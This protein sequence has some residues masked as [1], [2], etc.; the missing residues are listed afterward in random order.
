MICIIDYGM[1]NIHSVANA[2]EKIGVSYV[3]SNKKEDLEKA[4]GLI[5]PGVGAFPDCM[6]NLDK[7]NLITLIK[8]EVAK[9]KPLLGI[10]LGMQ[11][12]FES[13]DEIKETK[14][15]GLLSGKVTYMHGCSDKV[16]QVGW[17]EL[18]INHEDAMIKSFAGNT[19]AYFIHSFYATE[20]E[21]EDLMCYVEYGGL[22]VPAYVRKGNVLGMQ[23]HPE[24]S[25]DDGLAM[26]KVFK[27]MCV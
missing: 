24:K 12:L 18:M 19:Y 8:E 9:G 5:L 15:L 25:G 26:L 13:S 17:N 10:C 1:G 7:H 20:V 27:D 21:D 16:P 6:A 23:Y 4:K 22:K 3:V 14:G 11:A 2:L